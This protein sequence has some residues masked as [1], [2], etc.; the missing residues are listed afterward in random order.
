MKL[1][2][3]DTPEIYDENWKAMERTYGGDSRPIAYLEQTWLPY[4]DRFVDAWTKQ[5]LH[6]G[7]TVT[8]RIE[9]AHARLKG[10]LHVGT[11]DLFS[12]FRA[13]RQAWEN[14]HQNHAADES[15][16]RIRRPH[17][18]NNPFYDSVARKISK[19]ALMLAQDQ[20]K[21][22]LVAIKAWNAL[23]LAA[24]PSRASIL[25]ESECT[26]TFRRVYG[27]PC[28][29]EIAGRE[30]LGQGLRMDD[31]HTQW[32]LQGRLPL[33]AVPAAIPEHGIDPLL[34]QYALQYHAST[35]EAQEEMREGL[36][37]VLEVPR[38]AIQNPLVVRTRGRPPGATNR[39]TSLS[40][41]RNPSGFEVVTVELE[42]AQRRCGKCGEP[43][44]N[45][46]TCPS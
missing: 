7:N 38:T 26:G 3:S 41:Q 12:A 14:Q 9:G 13:I 18:L 45:R 32:W 19:H 46:R 29:H 25:P 27:I 2:R 44:H 15:S 11:H 8:S 34:A 43:G 36:E 40:T 10:Y 35:Q 24:R 33:P 28:K 5:Y 23:P 17:E 39:N 6:F 30:S 21:L 22:A 37:E 20:R 31:F 4:K 16:E 1:C 42:R